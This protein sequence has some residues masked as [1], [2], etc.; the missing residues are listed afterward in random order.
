M[1]TFTKFNAFTEHLAE[2]VHNLQ[3]GALVLALCATASAPV[4]A[5]STLS[6]LT[7]IS[8]TNLSSRALTVATS[9]Q[10]AGVYKLTVNDL[11]LTASGGPVAAFQYV[12][13]FN[14]TP[15]SPADP[16]IG[17]YNYGSALTLA[18]GETF[19][20]DA[21]GASGLLQIT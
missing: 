14:D 9:L 1:A 6:D 21:D 19:T 12:V 15:T 16:L 11:V 2:G 5:N 13:V 20:F 7:Q 8:Y 10:T 17:F 4:A 3:T 18:D